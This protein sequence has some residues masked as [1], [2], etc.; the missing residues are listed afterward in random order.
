MRLRYGRRGR[1][2]PAMNASDLV[3]RRSWGRRVARDEVLR[4]A[5]RGCAASRFRS[6]R[7]ENITKNVRATSLPKGEGT[8]AGCTWVIILYGKRETSL[9][10]TESCRV[11]RWTPPVRPS[12]QR[13]GFT[14]CCKLGIPG[15]V[16]RHNRCSSR[17][18][19]GVASGMQSAGLEKFCAA[20]D[21]LWLVKEVQEDTRVGSAAE[22]EGS[23]C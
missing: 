4:E 3:G 7:F 23:L 21:T 22:A 5:R 12:P 20:V 2:F 9:R 13:D 8:P 10:E 11:K 6:Y 15:E 17:C 16:Q 1:C 14:G 19:A 18:A